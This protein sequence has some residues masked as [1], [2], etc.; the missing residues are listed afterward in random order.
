MSPGGDVYPGQPGHQGHGAPG[1][2]GGGGVHQTSPPQ[3]LLDKSRHTALRL[4]VLAHSSLENIHAGI[5]LENTNQM[6]YDLSYNS[7][8]V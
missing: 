1:A 4:R 3:Q 5:I 8:L 2:G 7:M 6:F